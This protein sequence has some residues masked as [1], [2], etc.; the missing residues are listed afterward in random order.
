MKKKQLILSLATLIIFTIISVVALN[1]KAQITNPEAEIL[2]Q[3]ALIEKAQNDFDSGAISESEALSII[4]K[5]QETIND[6]ENKIGDINSV[7]KTPGLSGYAWSENVGWIKFA[8]PG[9]SLYD[10]GVKLQGNFLIGYAWSENVGWVV[11]GPAY[12][13]PSDI[14]PELK[15][16]AKYDEE[17]GKITGWAKIMV[18][19]NDSECSVNIPCDK[20]WADGWI[21]F[22]GENYGVTFEPEKG[23]IGTSSLK[24]ANRWAW[25]GN[26]TG[27]ID[28]SGVTVIKNNSTAQVVLE[29]EPLSIPVKGSS[30]LHWYS[31]DNSLAKG[32]CITT[33]GTNGWAGSSRPSPEGKF[34]TGPITTAGQYVFNISCPGNDG[35]YATSFATVSVYSTDPSMV[36]TTYCT[37]DQ[38][39]IE[40]TSYQNLLEGDICKSEPLGLWEKVPTPKATKN[41]DRGAT[42]KLTCTN[43]QGKDVSKTVTVPIKGAECSNL[44]VPGSGGGKIPGYKEN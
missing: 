12:E 17:T 41:V 39:I 19:D 28:F 10:G 15:G 24:D 4:E 1:T 26:V 22:S 9:G 27:W 14:S 33:N 35:G 38:G 30:S 23:V 37:Q 11:F 36:L 13:G 29:A 21:S 40:F 2:L 6:A 34:D 18:F 16:S 32:N 20:N 3:R 44:P 42:Y 8:E 7:P 31:P 5:A 43:S 25:G